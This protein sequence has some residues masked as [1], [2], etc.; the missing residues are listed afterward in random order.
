M[1]R[2]SICCIAM[3]RSIGV[4]R[5][6]VAKAMEYGLDAGVVNVAHR[7]GFSDAAPALLDFVDAF[8]KIDGS[9]ENHATAAKLSEKLLAPTK[10]AK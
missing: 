6:Y 4:C 2:V 3:P 9:A 1:V 5:A 10:K 8:A 7:Y